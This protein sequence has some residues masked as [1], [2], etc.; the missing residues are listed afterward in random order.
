MRTLQR[1]RDDPVRAPGAR[2]AVKTEL[3][4]GPPGCGL[5]Q[6]GSGTQTPTVRLTS[7]ASLGSWPRSE[8]L[9][10]LPL[11]SFRFVFFFFLKFPSGFL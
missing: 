5:T 6:P 7:L 1:D 11:V 9:A 10:T 2:N 4:P 8:S 3:R